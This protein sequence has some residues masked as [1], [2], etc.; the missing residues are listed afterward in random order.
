MPSYKY[1]V[2]LENGKISRGRVIAGNKAKAIET[3]KEE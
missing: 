2:L 1:R 3:L